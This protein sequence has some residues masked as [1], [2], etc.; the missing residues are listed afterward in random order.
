MR[1]T[2]RLVVWGAFVVLACQAEAFANEVRVYGEFYDDLRM[3]VRDAQVEVRFQGLVVTTSTDARG[4]YEAV[5]AIP[6]AVSSGTVGVYARGIRNE[7]EV[8]AVTGIQFG[9]ATM[10]VTADLV[11]APVKP[12]RVRVM[13]DV[14]PVAGAR[15]LVQSASP[16]GR[17]EIT[18]ARSGADGTVSVNLPEASYAFVVADRA[19]AR[20]ELVVEAAPSTAPGQR[21]READP[22]LQTSPPRSV[23]VLVTD[24]DTGAPLAGIQVGRFALRSRSMRVAPGAPLERTDAS[25]YATVSN[26]PLHSGVHLGALGS[27]RYKS[28][29]KAS[30][31][32]ATE[33]A[34]ALSPRGGEHEIR[35]PLGTHDEALSNE[36]TLEF[37]EFVKG[38]VLTRPL[39]VEEGRV[40]LLG[41]HEPSA[42]GLVVHEERRAARV[43]S[44]PR[45]QLP[46]PSG[47]TAPLEFVPAS[48]VRIRLVDPNGKPLA[49]R[50]LLL[51]GERVLRD[52]SGRLMPG[53]RLPSEPS[54]A[55]GVV[56]L[57]GVFFGPSRVKWI[58]GPESYG[59]VPLGTIHPR[60]GA[61]QS[62][63][64]VLCE[65]R[66]VEL[67]VTIDGK[68][69]L[70]G[71]LGV[72]ADAERL[73]T[74]ADP[75]RGILRFTLHRVLS[76]KPTW[77]SVG[78][79][80]LSAWSREVPADPGGAP[81]ILDV[82][83]VGTATISLVLDAEPDWV[84]RDIQL[85]R[86]DEAEGHW[87]YKDDTEY[88][89]GSYFGIEEVRRA[90]FACWRAFPRS[91]AGRYRFVHMPTGFAGEP[92]TIDASQ[93]IWVQH[94]TLPETRNLKG[95]VTT[96]PALD[97][98]G[99]R[100]ED[101]AGAP[102]LHW[103]VARLPEGEFRLRDLV[104]RS[105]RFSVQ[106]PVGAKIR[107]RVVHPLVEPETFEI[108]ADHAGPLTLTPTARP[109]LAIPIVREPPKR[110]TGTDVSA[111]DGLR[112][113]VPFTR[114]PTITGVSMPPSQLR[115][116]AVSQVRRYASPR[117]WRVAPT[118]SPSH[119]AELLGSVFD[120]ES[121]TLQIG[122]PSMGTHTLL[123]DFDDH[124]PLLLTNV[125]S[126]EGIRT[127]EPV[128]L[129][130]GTRLDVALQASPRN[131][132]FEMT[133]RAEPVTPHTPWVRQT[134][135][136]PPSEGGV[137]RHQGGLAPDT[138][139]SVFGLPAGTYKVRITAKR[140]SRALEGAP[141]E[142]E[143]TVTVDG[144]TP[145]RIVADF[146]TPHEVAPEADR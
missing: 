101:V 50:R 70:R 24:E 12:L 95:I 51:Q 9:L 102:A 17:H 10:A 131:P 115:R 33:L 113:A 97:L 40:V 46:D 108:A 41:H 79:I 4:R 62:Y 53:W 144:R 86:Y 42:R 49:G 36:A 23:R 8:A 85:H 39:R 120:K 30:P 61:T 119:S 103:S 68:P 140:S 2:I 100:I 31:G 63:T 29:T 72:H 105:G 48:L 80:G 55:D 7:V 81:L 104:N 71:S 110:R 84:G 38:G 75:L 138:V 127:L 6:D 112:A 78:G 28:S 128:R 1:T 47:R 145:T 64:F 123:L 69:G 14:K 143:T 135:Q 90:G 27:T 32:H 106:V 139:T 134:V 109:I 59:G 92:F 65:P 125:E 142:I 114:L 45:W 74:Q 34:I 66:E 22:T 132:A 25:G 26:L 87:V 20:A 3:P 44:P 56:L 11:A 16:Y 93:A 52:E 37:R 99:A 126:V 76:D 124:A 67:R 43:P 137:K 107:L 19:W 58:T 73:A 5:V 121:S 146:R 82:P 89:R 133:V 88:H 111:H 141:R 91:H 21:S 118:D 15:I 117:V 136:R 96:E 18:E 94:F 98:E 77:L 130:A 35:W 122:L 57:D 83:L 13:D 54:D 60:G 129:Q 116:D